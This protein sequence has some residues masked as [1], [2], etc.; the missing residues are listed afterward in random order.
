MKRKILKIKSLVWEIW[1]IIIKYLRFILLNLILFYGVLYI[2]ILNIYYVIFELK[3]YICKLI[4]LVYFK[5]DVI[6]RL[7]KMVV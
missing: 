3:I 7:V 2:W 6:R 5:I 1:G 4:F